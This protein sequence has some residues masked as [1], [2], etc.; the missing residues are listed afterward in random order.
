V[1]KKKVSNLNKSLKVKKSFEVK[2]VQK[3]Y[4]LFRCFVIGKA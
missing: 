3:A 4:E 2:Q 1:R